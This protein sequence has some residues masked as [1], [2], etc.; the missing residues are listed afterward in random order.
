MEQE[1]NRVD[2]LEEETMHA[3]DSM[4]EENNF[5]NDQV[6]DE[7]R[8][9]I[10]HIFSELK[11]WCKENSDPETIREH[12]KQAAQ[13]SREVLKST[14]EKVIEVSQSDQFKATMESGKDFLSGTVS[15]MSDGLKY[16][17]Q[18]LMKNDSVRNFVET[19][20]QKLDAV[21][22]NETVKKAVDKAEEVTTKVND[23][24]FTGIKNF[25]DKK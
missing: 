13:E 20:D 16:G 19:A 14:K 1:T 7:S 3:L 10:K 23:A 8:E 24:I 11:D 15:M 17:A 22:D 9:K 4:H 18:A 2:L 5:E 12:I 21:R 25:L 6:I